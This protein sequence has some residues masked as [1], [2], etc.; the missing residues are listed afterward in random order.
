MAYLTLNGVAV[1]C[2]TRASGEDE[3]EVVGQDVRA[4]NGTLLSTQQTSKRSWTVSTP[5]LTHAQAATVLTQMGEGVVC[6]GTFNNSVAVTCTV[7]YKGGRHP[8]AFNPATSMRVLTLSI[9][10]E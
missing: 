9:R 2:D 5:P 8:K 4:F 7:R 1:P 10:E 6:N 3:P